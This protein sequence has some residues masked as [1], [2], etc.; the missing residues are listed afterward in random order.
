MLFPPVSVPVCGV[1]VCEPVNSSI[2]GDGV[3]IGERGGD[4]GAE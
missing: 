1:S 3:V 4:G 2:G